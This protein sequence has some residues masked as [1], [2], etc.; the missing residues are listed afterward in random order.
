MP[1]KAVTMSGNSRNSYQGML[2]HWIYPALGDLKL[3]DITVA[4]ISSLLLSMQAAGN[5]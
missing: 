5:V 2:D 3:P 1:A 4:E